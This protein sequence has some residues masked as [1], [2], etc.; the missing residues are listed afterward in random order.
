MMKGVK[1]KEKIKM[2]P[3]FWVAWGVMLPLTEI[4]N[5]G[6]GANLQSKIILN[7]Y[8]SGCATEIKRTCHKEQSC[9]TLPTAAVVAPGRACSSWGCLLKPA[10]S[11]PIQDTPLVGN[12]CS[13]IFIS[14]PETVSELCC[15]WRLFIQSVFSLSSHGHWTHVG[16]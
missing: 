1:E 6:E 14:P 13:R 5:I 2:I 15:N 9:P 7:T 11:C 10:S 4:E 16:L 12:S 8:Y 3:G